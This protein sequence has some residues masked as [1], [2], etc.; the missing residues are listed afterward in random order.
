M[1]LPASTLRDIEIRP[2]LP[3]DQRQAIA[4]LPY[5][6]ATK[7]LVQ[8]STGLFD[9]RH[10]R[11][12]ATDNHLG[13]FWDASEPLDCARGKDDGTASIIAF[14]A[15]GSAAA[16]LREAAS[17]GGRE[18][19]SDLCWLG[20]SRAPVTAV[21]VG[22][23]SLSDRPRA[24]TFKIIAKAGSDP[25]GDIARVIAT[26]QGMDLL[27]LTPQTLSLESVF[28]KLTTTQGAS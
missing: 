14:L 2:E 11:A 22:D 21:H 28:R 26:A 24:T 25:R 12:F 1:T 8:S 15:G 10:A 16:P 18:L 27:Q 19:L 17:R 5:G 6:R 7:V 9:H 13:A 20:M 4:K 23:W 3:D